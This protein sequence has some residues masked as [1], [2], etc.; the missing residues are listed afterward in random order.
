MTNKSIDPLFVSALD[1]LTGALGVFIILNF[2]NTRLTGT[3]PPQPIAQVEQKAEK[4][5]RKNTE[6]RTYR[7][8]TEPRRSSPEPRTTPSPAQPTPATPTPQPKPTPEITP[9]PAPPQ[10]PTPPQDPVAVDLMKQTKGVVTLLLQQEGKAKQSVEF[11]LRQG[12]QTWKPSRSSKYQNNEFKYEKS[13]VYFYQENIAP[14]NYE[15]LVRVK[16]S[17]RNGGSQPFG[18]FGKII[19]P[20]QKAQTQHFGTY[21]AG[22]TDWISAGTFTVTPTGIS[23]KSSLPPASAVPSAE[24]A[25]SNTPAAPAPKTKPKKTGKWGV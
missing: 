7:P 23:F 20:G 12:S 13:L 17:D 4:P 11:M 6:S 2:L 21:A 18:L 8:A 14:G 16:R 19:P 24:P 5:E 25:G 9:T 10:P 1:I 3:T 15:V 22:G